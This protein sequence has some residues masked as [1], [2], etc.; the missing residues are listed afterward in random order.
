MDLAS[1]FL[2]SV[3]AKEFL[4][5]RSLSGFMR[6]V[7]RMR[8]PHIMRGRRRLYLKTDLVRVWRHPRGKLPRKPDAQDVAIAAGGL[9]DGQH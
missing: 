9:T 3:E 5:Y 1:P 2:T 8:I 4:R 6:A 7:H